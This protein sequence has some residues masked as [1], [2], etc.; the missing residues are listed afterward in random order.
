MTDGP[1][2]A[3]GD[4]GQLPLIAAPKAARKRA[5]RP[6]AGTQPVARV[7]VLT[8]VPHL[9]REFD[10]EVPDALSA[11]ARPGVRV[12]VRL[13]GRLVDGILL[14]RIAGSELDLQPIR[15]VHGPPVLTSEI[16]RLCRAVADR[17]AGTFADVV[18]F[19]VPPR[20]AR[21]E[22]GFPGVAAAPPAL[23]PGAGA[24]APAADSTGSGSS[25]FAAAGH[26]WG[27]YRF[28]AELLSQIAA[29]QPVRALWTSGPG[30]RPGER[31]A[32]LVVA[33][34]GSGRGAI[35]V[36]P[37]GADVE[38][39]ADA[40]QAHANVTPARLVAEAGPESRYRTF[41]TVLSGAS[42]VVVGTRP[43]VFAPV[44]DLG[45]IVVW[46]DGDESLAEPQAPGWHAREVA[47]LRSAADGCALVV[48]GPTVTLEAARMAD[49][50]WLATVEL[51]RPVLRS[52]MPRVQVAVDLA[53]GDPIAAAARVPPVALE[54]LR[55][56]A[57]QG[58]VLVHVPRTGYLPGLACQSCR[59][60]VRCPDCSRPMRADGPERVPTCP[61]HG[62]A[63]A[64]RCPL[65]G[66]DR[67]RATVVGV[68]RT[69]EEFGR[70]LPGTTV[71]TSSGTQPVRT[72][73]STRCLVVSTPGAEPDPGPAGYAALVL[74][75]AEAAL[76]RPGLRVAEEV[77]R[78]WL[79]AAALVRPASAG[80]RVLVVA[81]P[82]VREV[83]AMVRWDPRGYAERELAE[84]R[85]LALPPAV[86]TA[87]LVGPAL[88]AGGVV[89]QLRQELAERVLRC[90][91]PMPWS[92][93]AERAEAAGADR[94]LQAARPR[95]GRRVGRAGGP[96]RDV[97]LPTRADEGSD[98]SAWL[99]GVS[100]ADGPELT[101][102][103][104]RIQAARSTRRAPVVTV[105]MDPIRTAPGP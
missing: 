78:R 86:R 62:Q 73:T 39:I 79:H 11:E 38:R 74:L 31:I 91:G 46:D 57:E 41:L 83:Q 96:S 18:R 10:Y 65:C 51:P 93:R 22:K 21:A 105:R 33:A 61:A 32:E 19:A 1:G 45:L 53:H 99:I 60:Q 5:R 34:L 26:S 102:I 64:W 20:H 37:D 80:G 9:D 82:G 23:S 48:G 36:V 75:D 43:A 47:A 17:Y 101:G 104:R 6:A 55:S 87:L 95:S 81:D 70:A 56:G 42:R 63:L 89:T 49:S 94:A 30:E 8:P 40:V 7:A 92:G 12:R 88:E 24:G 16:A 68:R 58:P 35:V 3:A 69:A 71:I 84:R 27:R 67:V 103:L 72:L 59:E 13:A 90:S 25:T 52:T 66:D 98:P 54:V 76:S 44:P 15:S 100:I 14:E 50:G 97:L 28:G 85:T 29:G 4:S 77:L 2:R